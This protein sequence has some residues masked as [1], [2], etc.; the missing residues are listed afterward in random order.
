MSCAV[1]LVGPR[2]RRGE[3]EVFTYADEVMVVFLALFSA[4]VDILAV[5][6]NLRLVVLRCSMLLR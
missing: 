6:K 4:V 2:S 1:S 3:E 5:E